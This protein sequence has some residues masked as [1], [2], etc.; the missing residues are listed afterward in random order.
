MELK[1]KRLRKLDVITI[2]STCLQR[3][4]VLTSNNKGCDRNNY[5][6]DRQRAARRDRVDQGGRGVSLISH[7]R[8][9]FSV[10]H[11]LIRW[12]ARFCRGAVYSNG[13]SPILLTAPSAFA[14]C[15]ID[16][17]LILIRN[18]FIRAFRIFKRQ[19]LH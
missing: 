19:V 16:A 7:I 14:S 11:G 13:G 12:T 18:P 10:G 3:L 1:T 15:L 17:T 9:I 8:A 5:P 4:E 2:E 6:Y